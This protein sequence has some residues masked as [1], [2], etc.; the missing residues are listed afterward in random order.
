MNLQEIVLII[1]CIFLFSYL[2]IVFKL[3][4]S[5]NNLSY[6]REK[7]QPKVSVIVSL[8]NEE[9]N[10]NQL[11]DCL[12]QQDYPKDLYEIILVN[13]RSEDGT[14]QLLEIA[15]INHTNILIIKNE[16]LQDHFAPKKYAID[17]AIKQSNGE[18]I[19]LTDADGRPGIG[20][21]KSMVSCFSEKTGMVIGN[22]PYHANNVLQKILAMEYFSHAT[23]AGP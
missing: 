6:P 11:I 19:L 9:K 16:K 8:H 10:V 15:E 21:I 7:F 13:D 17:S 18:I 14:Q 23:I 5:L 2:L 22:A 12:Q 20:W 3:N 4:K 1:N